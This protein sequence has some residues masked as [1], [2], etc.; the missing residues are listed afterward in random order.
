MDDVKIAKKNLKKKYYSFWN[1]IPIYF[2]GIFGAFMLFSTDILLV[3]DFNTFLKWVSI[4][5]IVIFPALLFIG[6]FIMGL[7]SYFLDIVI[8]PREDVLY[9]INDKNNNK[10]FV[11]KKGKKINSEVDTSKLEV[12]SYYRVVRTSLYVIVL[13]EKAS[14][15]WETTIKKSYWIGLYS[16]MGNFE[17]LLLLPIVYAI[18]I[19]AIISVIVADGFAVIPSFIFAIVPIYLIIYDLVYK[20]KLRN[21]D[22]EINEA[23]FAKSYDILQKIIQLISV[24]CICFIFIYLYSKTSDDISKTLLLPFLGCALFSFGMVLSNALNNYKLGRIFAK[25]Y[26]LIFLLFWFGMITYFSISII[27]SGE[28]LSVLIF[29]IPFVIAGLYIFYKE[30]IKKSK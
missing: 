15:N 1:Y 24:S 6:L 27:K 14:D 20:L 21:P 29:L 5:A 25:G 28:N 3:K 17:D 18:A 16:P 10:L 23:K 2:F 26:I 12:N 30:F 4:N 7:I 19:P 22:N 13:K 8:P 9:L 11:N